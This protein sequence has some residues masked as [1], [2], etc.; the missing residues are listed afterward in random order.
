MYVVLSVVLA[1]DKSA[2]D[3][4]SVRE[5]ILLKLH[6]HTLTHVPSFSFPP[7]TNTIKCQIT[8]TFSATLDLDENRDGQQQLLYSH[9][10]ITPFSPSLLA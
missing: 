3:N 8:T 5:N 4:R 2:S 9:F 1:L 10:I 6:T 7:L